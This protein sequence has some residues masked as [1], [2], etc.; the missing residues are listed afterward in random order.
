MRITPEMRK[1]LIE[2]HGDGC[3]ISVL[4][5]RMGLAAMEYFDI[6]EAKPRALI[7]ITETPSCLVDGIQFVTG[8]TIGSGTIVPKD[9]GKLGAV[10]Y[11][12]ASDRAIRI[13]LARELTDEFE[14]MGAEIIQDILKGGKFGE[15]ERKKKLIQK[16]MKLSDEQLLDIMPVELSKEIKSPTTEQFLLQRGFIIHRTRCDACSEY[17][18]ETKT[19]KKDGKKLC[20]P[21]AGQGFYRII[22]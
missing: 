16:F 11:H 8:S 1:K 15:N 18:E 10:F 7:V 6:K 14:D 17:V 2:F 22:K 4:G 9:Y 12:R 3:P 21:C 5:A 19:V 20:M 13:K